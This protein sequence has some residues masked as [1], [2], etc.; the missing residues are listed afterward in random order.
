[1]STPYRPVV[2]QNMTGSVLQSSGHTGST[3]SVIVTG[4]YVNKVVVFGRTGLQYLPFTY[5]ATGSTLTVNAKFVQGITVFI[6]V[7]NN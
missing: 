2:A 5:S 4:K 1:M 7:V 3:G 6:G